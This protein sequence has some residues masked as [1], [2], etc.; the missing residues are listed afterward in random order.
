[1]DLKSLWV[2]VRLRAKAEDLKRLKGPSP[3]MD[4]KPLRVKAVAVDLLP[5]I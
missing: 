3:A 2:L 1:M 5:W 4:L